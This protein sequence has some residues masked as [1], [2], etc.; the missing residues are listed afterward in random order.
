MNKPLAGIKVLDLTRL[1]PGPVASLYLADLGADVIKIEDCGA[2]DY[3]RWQPPVAKQHSPFF[4]AINRN[5]R[6]LTLDLQKEAGK[7]IFAKLVED[8]DVLIESFRPGVMERLGLGYEKLQAINPKLIY[9]ALTG[10]GQTG[11]YRDRAGHD[12]NYLAI[13]GVLDQIGS[14][15]GPPAFSNLQIAD[16]AGGALSAVMGILAALVD[17][18]RSG[19][20][21]FVDVAMSDCSLALN[22]TALFA[23]RAWGEV[24]PRGQDFLSGAL[25]CYNIY[26]CGDGRYLALGALEPKFWYN[27][28]Q[29]VARPDL[30]NQGHLIDQAGDVVKAEVEKIL[31]ARSAA[32]WLAILEPAD[33]CATQVLTLD[34]AFENEQ[35]RARDLVIV[36]DQPEDGAI[37]QFAFPIK[38][39]DFAF[40]VDRPA[41]R[42]GEHNQEILFA[43]GYDQTKIDLLRQNKVIK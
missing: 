16:L 9:C 8:A 15:N 6:A 26:R 40:S 21:R 3:A 25:P 20:G 24:R 7:E 11:P 19:K 41:P 12:V 23:R 34:E 10:Y 2:G 4:L 38:M 31:S 29:A 43:L 30:K 28:C 5:K 13:T 37:T 32:E 17:Q 33:C 18:Q 1:L 35:I 14:A 27:F 42:M 39:S 22:V 36:V